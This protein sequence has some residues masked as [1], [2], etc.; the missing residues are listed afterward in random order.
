M[1]KDKMKAL[2]YPKSFIP[3]HHKVTD[4]TFTQIED[5]CLN[6]FQHY[7]KSKLGY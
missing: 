4:L 1:Q 2:L 7:A 6:S 3:D 5:N